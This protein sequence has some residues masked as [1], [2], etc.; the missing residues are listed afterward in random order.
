M[1][2]KRERAYKASPQL[3]IS[4]DLST[5]RSWCL[6]SNRP[7]Y[8]QRNAIQLLLAPPSSSLL[9]CSLPIFSNSYPPSSP[10]SLSLHSIQQNDK[11][12][13]NSLYSPNDSRIL[14]YSHTI[15]GIEAYFIGIL[16]YSYLITR[17]I[18]IRVTTK[19]NYSIL[20]E[21]AM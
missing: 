13:K 11:D 5:P 2:I 19:S 8:L 9:L 6:V 21:S 1:D 18:S 7:Y 3:E 12:L 17:D 20:Q 15:H 16:Q 10:P 4:H 14:N